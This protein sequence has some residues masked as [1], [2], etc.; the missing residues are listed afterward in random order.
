MLDR[1]V[2]DAL[3]QLLRQAP[4]QSEEE[5]EVIRRAWVQLRENEAEL[6]TIAST[7]IADGVASDDD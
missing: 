5:S 4:S 6:P 3:R 1:D 7:V 2:C